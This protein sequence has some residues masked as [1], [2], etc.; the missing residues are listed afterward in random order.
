MRGEEEEAVVEVAS[1]TASTSGDEASTKLSGK[2]EDNLSK[3]MGVAEQE[4]FWLIQSKRT[5]TLSYLTSTASVNDIREILLN[6]VM[7][8][9]SDKTSY[10]SWCCEPIDKDAIKNQAGQVTTYADDNG[11][12]HINVQKCHLSYQSSSFAPVSEEI[13]RT[14][15]FK[16]YFKQKIPHCASLI[17]AQYLESVH[18]ASGNLLVESWK[19]LPGEFLDFFFFLFLLLFFLL[20]LCVLLLLPFLFYSLFLSDPPISLCK[21]ISRFQVVVSLKF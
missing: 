9:T 5:D 6:T 14:R 19:R 17:K 11:M 13:S 16:Q 12:F 15:D 8:S 21:R 20:L 4:M 10:T 2:E 18:I 7:I 1:T 3:Y